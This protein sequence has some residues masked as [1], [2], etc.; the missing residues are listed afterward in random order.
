MML[1]QA[2]TPCGYRGQAAHGAQLN[3][4][5]HINLNGKRMEIDRATAIIGI[6]SVALFALPFVL[7]YRRRKRKGAQQLNALREFARQH[8]SDI[9]EH[10]AY[11]DDVLGL[12]TRRNVLLHQSERMGQLVSQHIPLAQVRAC[13]VVKSERSR[14]GAQDQSGIERV[15]LNLTSKDKNLPGASILLYTASLGAQLNGEIQLAE[16]WSALVNDRLKG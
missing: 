7:D 4:I 5:M 15:E 3:G 13:S 12:D 16:K 9:H 8:N 2:T 6:I 1:P 11:G 10:E 14:K